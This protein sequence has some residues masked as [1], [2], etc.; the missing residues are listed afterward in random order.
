M[1]ITT[2]YQK[3]R[4]EFGRPVNHFTMSDVV[5][6]D[7][8]L[9]EKGDYAHIERNPTILDIQAIAPMSETYVRARPWPR[10]AQARA[11]PPRRRGGSRPGGAVPIPNADARAPCAGRGVFG[12]R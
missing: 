6:L 12:C 3:E 11:P 9:P 10:R 7:E 8:F 2:V 4:H 1:D 5:V